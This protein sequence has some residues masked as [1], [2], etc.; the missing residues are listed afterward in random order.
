MDKYDMVVV[1]A[2]WHGLVAAKVYLELHPDEHILVL[3][4]E[5]SC[6]GTWSQDRLYPGLKSNNLLGTYEYPDYPMTTETYGVKPGEH[7]PA[8][9]LHRY[10]TDFAKKFGVFART[11]FNTKVT[12]IE[13]LENGQW[14]ISISSEHGCE[15]LET[16]KIILASGLTSQPNMPSYVGMKDFEAPI[17]H[18]KDF[19]RNG[20]TVKTAKK[21]VIVGG[22]KS[23]M[24]AAYAYAT[25]GVEVDM[26]IRENGNGPVWISYPWVMGGKKRLEQLLAVR[27]MTWFSPCI[28]GGVDGYSWI[29]NFLHGTAVGRFVV[30]QFWSGLEGEVIEKNGYA[31]NS[32]LQKLQPWNSAFW[33]GSGLS[34]HNYDTDFFQ[35]VKDGRVRIHSKVDVDHLTKHNVH[36]TNGEILS[37]DVLVAATGWRKEPAIDFVNFGDAGIGLALSEEE[38]KRL[39]TA[40]DEK[41]LT[42][43]PCL[44]DQPALNFKQPKSPF[45]LYRYIVPPA[46]KANR[47]IAFAGL[48]SSV[49]TSTAASVQALWISAFLDGKL[50]YEASSP[51]EVT[52]EVMLHTQWNKW[53]HPTGYGASL[54]DF[55]FDGLP[56]IDLMMK[57]MGLKVNRKQGILADITEPYG[58]PDFAGI[59]A[60][61]REQ[62]SKS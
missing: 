21:A 55:A 56:Y 7:I 33:I 36:L 9:V 57:D 58:P 30:K 11:R 2:G 6:G 18:A 48:V 5:S 51:E 4:A 25:N 27:W 45:R 39:A 16:K 22:A 42:K 32:E 35:M 49:S 28:F 34:I 17:F 15:Q 59:V 3:E 14:R 23:A 38:Q 62:P 43:F 61:W 44:R 54:P 13:A 20:D 8:A 26:V 60:E 1:G 50:D 29:R 37:A 24:D 52:D 12:S 53:R 31:S 46:L 41:V 40:A 47:N 10:L 19:C